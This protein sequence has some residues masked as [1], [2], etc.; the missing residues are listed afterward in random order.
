MILGLIGPVVDVS[1]VFTRLSMCADSRARCKLL[2]GFTAGVYTGSFPIT[3]HVMSPLPSPAG[4][5]E[6]EEAYF[7]GENSRKIGAPPGIV[8]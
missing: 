3:L 1:V 8:T 2:H 6:F 4:K 7:G 5:H